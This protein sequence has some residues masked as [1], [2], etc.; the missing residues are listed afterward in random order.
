[1]ARAITEA[2]HGESGS[3]LAFLPGQAEITRTAERLEGRFDAGTTVVP[4]YGNLG[5]R[6]QDAAI[7]PA[8]PG[9]R[10]CPPNFPSIPTSR[11]T[12]VT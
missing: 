7:R 11:A 6:E 2:H 3:I 10:A 9:T 5:Q 12:V 8:A 1:M 4:L